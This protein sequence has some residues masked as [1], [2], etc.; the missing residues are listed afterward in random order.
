MFGSPKY[1]YSYFILTRQ[2]TSLN[3]ILHIHTYIC[4]YY[5]CSYVCQAYSKLINRLQLERPRRFNDI[6]LRFQMSAL[7][8]LLSSVN[9]LLVLLLTLWQYGILLAT[10]VICTVIFAMATCRYNHVVRKSFVYIKK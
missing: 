1:A 2:C 8:V 10:T 9:L 5:V 7:W 6:E 3:D 4:M